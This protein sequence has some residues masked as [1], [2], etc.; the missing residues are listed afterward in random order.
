MNEKIKKLRRFLWEIV[1]QIIAKFFGSLSYSYYFSVVTQTTIMD[2]DAI[3]DV[4]NLT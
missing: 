3:M 2:V 4:A 1:A